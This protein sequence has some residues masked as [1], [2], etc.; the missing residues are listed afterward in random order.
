MSAME[1]KVHSELNRMSHTGVR[2]FFGYHVHICA[3]NLR[4]TDAEVYAAVFSLAQRGK[5]T[6]LPGRKTMF[7]ISA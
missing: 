1:T 7:E 2:R 5:I 3:C 6:P 4:S